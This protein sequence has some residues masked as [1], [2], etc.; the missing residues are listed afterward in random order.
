MSVSSFSAFVFL[1]TCQG[2][3]KMRVQFLKFLRNL[4]ANEIF[5]RTY[6]P[7][8]VFSRLGMMKY[9]QVQ[10]Q[11]KSKISFLVFSLNEIEKSLIG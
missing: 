7:F 5:E 3:E 4:I 9:A 8:H 6:K 10:A 1:F 11:T 2:C